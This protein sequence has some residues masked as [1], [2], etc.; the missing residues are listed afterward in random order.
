M[1]NICEMA[2]DTAIVTMSYS[3]AGVSTTASALD[4]SVP[5]GSALGPLKFI[6]YTEDASN[7]FRRHGVKFHLLADDKQLE[8][9]V[10]QRSCQRRQCH[11]ATAGLTA[12]LT[13][14]HGLHGV[15]PDGCQKDRTD[16]VRVAYK[17]AQVIRPR[18][19]HNCDVRHNSTS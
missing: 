17:P 7:V 4:C 12:L 1:L 13:L 18:S 14:Q 19:G 16:M 5:Q 10:C 2:K 6:C 15:H 9:S 8:A 11:P 3:Y